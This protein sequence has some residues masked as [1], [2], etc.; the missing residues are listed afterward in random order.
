MKK[1]FVVAAASMFAAGAL[2]TAASAQTPG[3]PTG[4]DTKLQC[5][6]INACKGQSACKS[7]ANACKGQNDC[8]GRGWSMTTTALECTVQG[9]SP[10][11]G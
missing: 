7:S 11:G 3:S 2:V 4:T 1:S 9:G 10:G 5:K 6:G 8:K